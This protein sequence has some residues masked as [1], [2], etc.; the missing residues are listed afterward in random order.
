MAVNHTVTSA[1]ILPFFLSPAPFFPTGT[2]FHRPFQIHEGE[3]SLAMVLDED[4]EGLDQNIILSWCM[5]RN[6]GICS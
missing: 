1:S 4:S 5:I 2:F 6:E 3:K